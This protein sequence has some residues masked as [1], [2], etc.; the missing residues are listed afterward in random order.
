MRHCNLLH[1][2]QL[3]C[4]IPETTLMIG[5]DIMTGNAERVTVAEF[6]LS[7]AYIGAMVAFEVL[8][9]IA[10]DTTP[11]IAGKDLLA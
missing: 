8:Y 6:L 1:R 4:G 5:Y 2:W 9:A 3:A 7:F 10:E 11:F